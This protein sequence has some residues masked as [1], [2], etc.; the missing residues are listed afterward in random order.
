MLL[1][2]PSFPMNFSCTGCASWLFDFETC[3]SSFSELHHKLIMVLLSI[4]SCTDMYL[5]KLV[6]PYFW[7]RFCRI[8]Q[9]LQLAQ[10]LG[11]PVLASLIVVFTWAFEFFGFL[12]NILSF[13]FDMWY[14]PSTSSGDIACWIWPE[15]RTLSDWIPKNPYDFSDLATLWERTLF[16]S[17]NYPPPDPGLGSLLEVASASIQ[18]PLAQPGACFCAERPL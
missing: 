6:L 2:S 15:R 10:L 9:P 4:S 13:D 17:T 14:F 18:R 11:S 5:N 12:R 16:W 3:L 1:F 7:L 8:L